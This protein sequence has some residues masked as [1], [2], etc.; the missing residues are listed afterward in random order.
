[1]ND[2]GRVHGAGP[3]LTRHSRLALPDTGPIT[4]GKNT[5]PFAA[6]LN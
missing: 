6:G 1:M 5:A 4:R 2:G 3:L